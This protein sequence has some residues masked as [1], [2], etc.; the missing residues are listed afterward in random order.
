M[1]K[2]KHYFF[3]VDKNLIRKYNL[4]LE[5]MNEGIPTIYQGL[6]I[7]FDNKLFGYP[8]LIVRND[9]L[10]KITNFKTSS[11]KEEGN[12]SYYYVVVDIKYS[13][14]VFR[15]K[16]DTLVNTGMFGCF[17]SQLIIYNSCLTKMQKYDPCCVYSWKKME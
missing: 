17:K 16:R 3:E 2:N 12:G 6:V 8:D 7:D 4:T 1:L 11:R 13:N 10:N 15:R 14:L 9:Y 5:K